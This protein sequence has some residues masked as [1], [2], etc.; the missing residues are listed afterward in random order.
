M[1]IRKWLK[2]ICFLLLLLNSSVKG[3]PFLCL[4]C[5]PGFLDDDEEKISMVKNVESYLTSFRDHDRKIAE[6]M[7]AID[8][9]HF[10]PSHLS[11]KTYCDAAL[12]IEKGQSIS[13]PS[14]VARMLQVLKLKEDDRVLE[15]GTGSGWNAALI[16]YIAKSGNVITLERYKV[17]S[18]KAEEKFKKLKIKNIKA[19]NEDFRGLE[20]KFDKIIFTA[21][22]VPGQEEMIENVARKNLNVGGILLCRF[23]E[24]SLIIIN[25]TKEGLEKAYSPEEYRFVPL[26]T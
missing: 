6:A 12:P 7:K 24:G 23:Q 10:I 22:I 2:I 3:F 18:Q 25:K 15:I 16:A 11:G 17:L 1:A 20:D 4:V 21:G 26:V 8:R 9:K 5:D 14:T 13:Q 19:S